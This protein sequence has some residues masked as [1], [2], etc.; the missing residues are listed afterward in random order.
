MSN[1]TLSESALVDAALAVATVF[2]L[3]DQAEVT[4]GWLV[5]DG[6]TVLVATVAGDATGQLQLAVNDEVARRLMSDRERLAAGLSQAL[7]VLAGS[8][9]TELTLG[10]IEVASATAGPEPDRSV[11][12]RDGAKLCALLGVTLA[13][14]TDPPAEPAPSNTVNATP[15]RRDRCGDR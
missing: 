3:G 10:E 4:R 5:D 11:E 9:G 15:F 12:I 6:D 14:V 13:G 2:G 1:R 8:L 7:A